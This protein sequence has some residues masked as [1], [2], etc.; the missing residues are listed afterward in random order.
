MKKYQLF[1]C[2]LLSFWASCTTTMCAQNGDQILDGIGE[3]GLIARYVFD[4]DA[5]DWSR[6]NLHATIQDVKARF[7]N[8]EQ[9]G[10]VLSL[11]A[12]SNA[13][14]SIP[15]EGLIG[16]ESLSITGW[17]YLRSAQ[18]GQRFFDFGKNSKA[19]LS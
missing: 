4:G 13:F 14:V 15:G 7:V 11:P 8:D 1:I 10:T 12:D 17:I 9:F 16:E 3:T 18:K 2:V 6:N 19:H 5:K